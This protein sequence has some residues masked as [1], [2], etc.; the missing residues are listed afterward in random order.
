MEFTKAIEEK[1]VA[2]QK[3]T[4]A[5]FEAQAVV[6]KAEG[7]AKEQVLLK[8]SLTSE[9]LQRL[10]IEKWSGEVPQFVAGESGNFL[11]QVPK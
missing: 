11:F 7:K 3:K 10:W 1:Q 4:Q 5:E 8:E 6:A 2:E 9:I